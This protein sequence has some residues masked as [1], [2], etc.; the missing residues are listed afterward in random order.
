MVTRELTPTDQT[1]SAETSEGAPTPPEG[2]TPVK[3]E[4]LQEEFKKVVEDNPEFSDYGYTDPEDLVAENGQRGYTR[5][6]FQDPDANND[7]GSG[8][9]SGSG[10]GGDSSGGSGGGTAVGS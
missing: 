3:E 9:G 6:P 2:G 4:S 10:S 1:S 8:S 7:A 5:P